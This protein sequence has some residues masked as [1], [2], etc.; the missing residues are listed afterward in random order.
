MK[1]KI[2]LEIKKCRICSSENMTDILDLG[3]QP[4]A[5]NLHKNNSSQ[6]S[7]PLK[8]VFCNKCKTAQLSCTVNPKK[9]FDH[10]VWVSS[11]SQET[12]K[13]SLFFYIN[14]INKINKKN[15]LDV[16]EIAS[17]D[18][19]FLNIFKK[20]KHNI[21]GVEPAKNIS[22]IA[23]KQKIRT[24]NNYFSNDI[25]KKILKDYGAKDLVIARNVIPHVANLHSVIKGI[26][27]VLGK[28]GSAA[29]EFHYSKKIIDELHYDSIYH[30]HLFYFTIKTISKIFGMYGL[31]PYDVFSS[32]ISGGSLVLIFSKNKFK[33]KT[34]ILNKF[35]NLE[36][37]MGIN[38]KKNWIK[39]GRLSKKHSL[40]LIK[41]INEKKKNKEIFGYGASARSSTLLN[42]CKFD[43][44][45]IK[46]IFDKN[47]L[48]S[49]L[50][51][52][53]TNIQIKKISKLVK[54]LNSLKS[55]SILVLAWNFK[56]EIL[57]FLKS[58]NY[59]G[60]VIIPL[61]KIRKYDI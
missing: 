30:E 52:P 59:K 32:P 53:G 29:I 21:L 22:K 25:A 50:Y 60:E 41:L 7:V 43:N 1:K 5:N 26:C 56:S 36:K 23:N 54:Y 6:I 19:L 34:R 18:G 20:K 4:L 31:Y 61:P 11:T 57:K 40:S 48:K 3:K 10:Y 8:L 15:K 37:K 47:D 55:K 38:L 17:N 35:I 49:N 46:K 58:K 13:H 39:F 51:T 24:L 14:L 27:N 33:K 2:F 44:K 12:K 9:L 16:L 28:D 45:T 42:Y